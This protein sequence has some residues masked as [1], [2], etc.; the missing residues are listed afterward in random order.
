MRVRS[1]FLKLTEIQQ[2]EGLFF[3]TQS[4]F[5]SWSF[6]ATFSLLMSGIFSENNETE[7]ECYKSVT[8]LD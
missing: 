4:Q 7:Q 2:Q 5:E 6:G 8:H 1:V 3:V